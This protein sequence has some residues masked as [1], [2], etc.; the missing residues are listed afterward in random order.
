LPR[1]IAFSDGIVVLSASNSAA[2]EVQLPLPLRPIRTL[3]LPR[4]LQRWHLLSLDAPTV[5][6]VWAWSAARDFHAHILPAE[7]AAMFLAVWMIYAVDR[8]LDAAPSLRPPYSDLQPRHFFHLRYRRGFVTLIIFALVP[9]GL[10]LTRFP[11]IELLLYLLM[12]AVLT[13]WFL[14]IH[15]MGA[16]FRLPK[17]LVLGAFFPLAVFLPT[18]VHSRGPYT[19]LIAPAISF[20]LLCALNALFIHRWECIASNPLPG[21]RTDDE[22]TRRLL[23]RLRPLTLFFCFSAAVAALILRQPT[24][25]FYSAAALSAAGLLLLDRARKHFEPTD[26]RALVDLVLLSP[27]LLAAVLR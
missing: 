26:L 15:T 25:S 6:C 3:R 2:P 1:T 11:A 7:L 5:A 21:A 20:G 4:A 8:L 9:L 14:L 13:G 24:S 22:L 12:L 18:A 19:Q 27:L 23:L 17:E 10:F 16:S